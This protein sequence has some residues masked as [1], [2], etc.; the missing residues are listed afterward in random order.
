MQ[1]PTNYPFAPP[2][3]KF[4]TKIYHPSIKEN[5]EICIE[6]L[7]TGYS[8]AVS[9]HESSRL[10]NLLVLEVIVSMLMDPPTDS[11]LVPEIAQEILTN[12]KQFEDKAKHWTSLFAV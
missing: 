11:A 5:G 4:I 12:R 8:P 6:I 3:V 2:T 1:F 7:K 9:V 10:L